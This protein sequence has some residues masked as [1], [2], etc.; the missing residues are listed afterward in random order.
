MKRKGFTLIELIVMILLGGALLTTM[1]GLFSSLFAIR[2]NVQTKIHQRAQ[3][4]ITDIKYSTAISSYLNWDSSSSTLTVERLDCHNINYVFNANNK[5]ITKTVS[6]SSSSGCGSATKKIDNAIFHNVEN[7][8]MN[9][10][11]QTKA[12]EMTLNMSWDK[13]KDYKYILQSSIF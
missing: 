13:N 2:E 9:W 10:D 8:D 12:W 6:M 5:N 1:P 4:I 7:F 3:M 11:D